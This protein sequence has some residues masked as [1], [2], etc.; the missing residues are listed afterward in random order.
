MKRYLCKPRQ[1]WQEI[2]SSIG[3]TYHT[4]ENGPY[5]SEGV[6]Y[7]FNSRQIDELEVA[8]NELHELCIK[9]AEY[10][11]EKNL[12]SELG[13]PKHVIPGILQSWERDDFS[14]YGRF[15]LAY[16]GINPPKLL[17]YNADTPT[18]LVEAALAQWFWKEE[19]FASKDQFNSIH[20][21]LIAAWKKSPATLIHFAG[22]DKN[23]EDH[24]TISYLVDTAIQAGLETKWLAISEIGYD[25]SARDFVDVAMN[26]VLGSLFK[27]YPW[28][29]MFHEDFGQYLNQSKVQFIEPLWKSLLSNKGIL[30]ILWK[31]FPNHPN[32]LPC[33]TT[34]QLLGKNYVRKPILSREGANVSVVKNGITVAENG[35]EYGEEG[36]IYQELADIPLFDGFRPIVGSWVINHYAC[37]IGIREDNSLITGNLSRFVPHVFD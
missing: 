9:A 14:L 29:W 27:L 33:Y 3:L 26:K 6:Y 16:D 28:E 19:V 25:E 20:E 11:I 10:V 1:N 13:I 23:L 35:G 31:L 15:D 30:P 32:L 12:W 8:T 2:V 36:F 34:P 37:G 7:E 4:H 18:A 24:Q 5:W 21:N 22:I 17:E